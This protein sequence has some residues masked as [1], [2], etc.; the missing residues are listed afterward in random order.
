MV[1][2]RVNVNRS[3][4][5]ERIASGCKYDVYL[6]FDCIYFCQVWLYVAE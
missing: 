1:N 4:E 2:V 3:T 6:L 5:L